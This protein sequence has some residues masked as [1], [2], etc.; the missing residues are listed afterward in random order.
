L[1]V[2]GMKPHVSMITLGV[3]NVKRSAE[4]YRCLGFTPRTNNDDENIVFFDLVSGVVLALYWREALAEDIRT[5]ST[6]EGFRA[7]TLAHCVAS[8]EEVDH[9][10]AEA[11]R[12]GAILIK[13]GEKVFW[14]GY[15]GYFA[16]PDGF[17]WEVAYNPFTDM[18]G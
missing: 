17:L 4:F 6:G 10:L 1:E 5:D 13:R 12:C 15:S 16:D 8:E 7:I 9:T 18:T 11:V 3:E 2:N 14:G